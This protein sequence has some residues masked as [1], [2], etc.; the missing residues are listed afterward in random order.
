MQNYFKAAAGNY[1]FEID[2]PSGI[3]PNLPF[4]SDP[5]MSVESFISVI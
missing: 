1:S 2:R 3:D 4:S 5:K